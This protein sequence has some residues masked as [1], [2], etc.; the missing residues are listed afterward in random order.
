MKI[1]K[2]I[3]IPSIIILIAAA[4]VIFAALPLAST[5][6]ADSFRVENELSSN[7]EREAIE[8]EGENAPAILMVILPLIKVTIFMGV[9]ALLTIFIRRLSSLRKSQAV[10]D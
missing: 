1:L 5:E 7:S 9:G 3:L 2:N 6:W 10:S 4:L 8:Q